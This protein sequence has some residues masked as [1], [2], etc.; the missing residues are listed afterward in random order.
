MFQ[1]LQNLLQIWQNHHQKDLAE[2][3]IH[4]QHRRS[5]NIL[6][7]THVHMD[8]HNCLETIIIK[9]R[10]PEIE[11]IENLHAVFGFVVSYPVFVPL[12]G[13]ICRII[14]LAPLF[15]HFYRTYLRWIL[16]RRKSRDAY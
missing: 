14:V 7:S 8:H 13:A 6:C 12:A 1:N 3:V 5:V 15:R 10:P 11:K 2:K 9:G 4:A 16:W